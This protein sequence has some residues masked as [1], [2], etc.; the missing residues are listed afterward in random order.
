M[1]P[2]SVW[3]YLM[4]WDFYPAVVLFC[5]LLAAIYVRGWL[6]CRKLP[7]AP[8]YAPLIA[9]LGGLCLIYTVMHTYVDYL[10]QHMLWIHRVQ[11][12]VLHHL[13][14]FL[15]LLGAPWKVLPAGLP[16][17]VTASLLP[18]LR[19][20][21]LLRG[22]YLGLQNPLVAPLLFVGLI[23]FWLMPDIHFGA[24]LSATRYQLMN[25]SMLLDGLLFWWLMLDPSP[26]HTA[27]HVGYGGRI[28]ILSLIVPPQIILGA[29]IALADQ[30]LYPVYSVCGRAWPISPLV[31]QQIAGLVTW[32]PTSMMSVIAMLIVLSRWMHE[33]DQVALPVK[34]GAIP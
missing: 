10:S 7:Q 25:W 19:R 2:T 1:Q 4:P 16:A 21:P 11:H 5:A 24:M 34:R 9:F 15:L 32:I 26:G 33:R 6:R 30:S 8:G 17:G 28:V 12:L 29:H 27:G 14:P 13:G 3:M 31:D 23:Y 20:N 22:L 18:K